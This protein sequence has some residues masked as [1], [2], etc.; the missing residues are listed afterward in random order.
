[1]FDILLYHM[2]YEILS[3]IAGQDS[4]LYYIALLQFESYSDGILI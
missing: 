3:L 4:Y 1:M 2:C